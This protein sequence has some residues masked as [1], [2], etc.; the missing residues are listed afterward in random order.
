VGESVGIGLAT[1]KFRWFKRMPGKTSRNKLCLGMPN[2]LHPA[3]DIFVLFSQDGINFP[4]DIMVTTEVFFKG[5]HECC[6]STA[7]LLA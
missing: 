5:L 4:M 1:E 7:L 6:V 3:T 2:I